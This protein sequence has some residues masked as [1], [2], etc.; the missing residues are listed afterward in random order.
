MERLDVKIM[1]NETG[2]NHLS[3]GVLLAWQ[4]AAIEAAAS[5]HQYIEIE[6]LLIGICSLGKIFKYSGT[7]AGFEL[8][9]QYA[10]QMEHQAVTGI[11]LKQKLDEVQLRREI[12]Q[13]LGTGQFQHFEKIIHRSPACKKIFDQA[14]AAAGAN[15]ELNC[16]YLLDAIFSNPGAIISDV[17]RAK[18]LEVNDH[19]TIA[20]QI[21]KEEVPEV[22]GQKP[23]IIELNLVI[24]QK[25]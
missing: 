17:I 8:K 6:H 12:R 18:G 20:F 10:L 9:Q 15:G 11:L 7:G 4:I 24:R 14:A 2:K 5:Q 3:T 1:A 21:V 16:L 22:E 19:Q 13:K 25:D 23:R